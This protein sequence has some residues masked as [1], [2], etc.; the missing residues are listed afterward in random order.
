[1]HFYAIPWE[2]MIKQRRI[3]LPSRNRHD[4]LGASSLEEGAACAGVTGQA[5]SC[6]QL[7]CR[8][9]P[10]LSRGATSASTWRICYQTRTVLR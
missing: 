9:S 7:E 8:D 6:A 5:D 4:H 1:M 3:K 10:R 2:L